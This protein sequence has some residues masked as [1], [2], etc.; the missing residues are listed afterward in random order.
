M[1]RPTPHQLR[2][3]QKPSGKLASLLSWWPLVMAFLTWGSWVTLSIFSVREMHARDMANMPPVE[4]KNRI[5][6]LE[7][8]TK[9]CAN[10]G[11]KV[12]ITVQETQRILIELEKLHRTNK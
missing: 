5:V 4:W 6:A 7:E 10:N 1:T 3:M 8:Q 11:G 9:Q 12:L 2:A